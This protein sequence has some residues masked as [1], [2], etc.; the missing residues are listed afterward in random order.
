MLAFLGVIVPWLFRPPERMGRGEKAIWTFVMLLFFGLELRTLYLDRDEHDREQANIECNQLQQFQNIAYTLSA[1]ITASS[2]QFDKTMGKFSE[3]RIQT[4]KVLGTAQGIANQENQ[5]ITAIGR[6]AD[7]ITEDNNIQNREVC[8]KADS[9]YYQTELK[10]TQFNRVDFQ[11]KRGI[12]VP[13]GI[14]KVYTPEEIEANR[15]KENDYFAITIIPGFWEVVPQL[16]ARLK[17][18]LPTTNIDIVEGKFLEYPP[19][20][21]LDGAL[22]EL[23]AIQKEV[24]P[25]RL[26][27][28]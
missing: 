19:R 5:N 1:A 10:I 8:A 24:C 20:P 2:K 15:E 14:Q 6:A 3:A 13:S 23:R 9:F 11:E 28:P 18:P 21:D 12:I 17:K 26:P 4:D 16:Q 7:Q 25:P 22:G 27:Q